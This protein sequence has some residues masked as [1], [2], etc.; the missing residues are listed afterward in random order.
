M[1]YSPTSMEPWRQ[2]LSR[3]VVSN[4]EQYL[5]APIPAMHM[6]PSGS[7]KQAAMAVELFILID[8]NAIDDQTFT[9]KAAAQPYGPGNT[10]AVP[11]SPWTQAAGGQWSLLGDK[12]RHAGAG[13]SV[14]L[15]QAGLVIGGAT[16]NTSF[17]VSERIAG[18]VNLDLGGTNGTARSTNATFAEAI[19][20]GG[21]GDVDLSI[22]PTSAFQGA[23]DDVTIYPNTAPTD[24]DVKLYSCREA[25][26]IYRSTIPME[27]IVVPSAAS[28][29]EQ[30]TRTL[31]W[32]VVGDG[33]QIGFVLASAYTAG[34][35]FASVWARRFAWGSG[36]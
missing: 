14:A 19:V 25:L 28:T 27:T 23:V 31:D 24:C 18:S 10:L 11:A 3:L 17:T 9:R 4:T 33:L 22:E 26:D 30:V 1:P 34:K 29:K 21:A 20:A 8:R 16:Y 6:L 15:K 2:V 12:A 5:S 13:A 35:L 32:G 36:P 7:L